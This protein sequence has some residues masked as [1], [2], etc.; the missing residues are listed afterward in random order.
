[1]EASNKAALA[2][3]N[4]TNND[5][6]KIKKRILCTSRSA[7]NTELLRRYHFVVDGMRTAPTKTIDCVCN[8]IKRGA[9]HKA[10]TERLYK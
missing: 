7:F 8:L 4:A 9:S 10:S 1:M 2:D 5:R 3:G 6:D